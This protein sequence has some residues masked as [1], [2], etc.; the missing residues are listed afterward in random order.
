MD[1]KAVARK[2]LLEH[3][4]ERY[5][6]ILAKE[7]NP[8]QVIVFGSLATGQVHEWSDIDLVIVNQTRLPFLDRLCK[9]QGLLEPQVGTDILYY[10]PEEFAK[11]CQERLFF[12]EEIIQKGKVVYERNS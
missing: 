1:A 12:Q 10:T 9:A 3:E 8:D 6:K 11:L 5:V 2:E 7:E 4:L